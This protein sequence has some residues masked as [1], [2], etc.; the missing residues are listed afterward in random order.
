VKYTYTAQYR[1]IAVAPS[2]G[3]LELLGP[4]TQA[5]LFD[6]EFEPVTFC[7]GLQSRYSIRH[8]FTS[9]QDH[10]PCLPD[11]QNPAL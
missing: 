3:T 9:R 10:D 1:Y 11:R 4:P 8:V 6:I 7:F 5:R 2:D